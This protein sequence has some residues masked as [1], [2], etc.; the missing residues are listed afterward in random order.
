MLSGGS[1]EA[2]CWFH[3]NVGSSFGQQMPSDGGRG[4][5]LAACTPTALP[6]QPINSPTL[7]TTLR[8]WPVRYAQPTL[9]HSSSS[10]TITLVSRRSMARHDSG[11]ASAAE[12]VGG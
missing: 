3:A 10:G 4:R 11:T 1:G 2:E 5:F 8:P 6:K 12:P 9:R 7:S